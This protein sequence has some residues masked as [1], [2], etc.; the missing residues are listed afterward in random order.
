MG[1]MDIP[2]SPN[3]DPTKD[4][5][6][7]P[8][9]DKVTGNPIPGLNPDGSK[10]QDGKLRLANG[11]LVT[12]EYEAY[13]AFQQA[14]VQVLMDIHDEAERTEV[15]HKL[16]DKGFIV[17]V[18]IMV[19]QFDPLACMVVRHNQG[20][21]WVPS[22]LMD[23]IPVMPGLTFGGKPSYDPNKMPAG[24]IKVSTAFAL[25]FENTSMWLRGQKVDIF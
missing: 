19:W 14:E 3:A 9:F 13:W 18:P 16:A 4:V 11:K 22:A 6:R 5:V 25:G 15:A 12:N 23:P 20:F 10:I 8:G 2:H 21:T 17:D 24:A 1:L 7:Q